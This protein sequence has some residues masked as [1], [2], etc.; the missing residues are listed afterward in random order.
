MIGIFKKILPVL[1]D[2]PGKRKKF[3]KHST[4]K[5]R[6]CGRATKPCRRCGRTAGIVGQYNIRLCRQC[7]RDNAKK[8]GFKQYS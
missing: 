4:P 7:F 5:K 2:K 6:S 1:K 3:M 8:I